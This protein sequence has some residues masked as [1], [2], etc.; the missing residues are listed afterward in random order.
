MQLE[1]YQITGQSLFE[2]P[3]DSEYDYKAEPKILFNIDFK[4]A[5]TNSSFNLEDDGSTPHSDS[6]VNTLLLDTF[7]DYF[8]QLFNNDE[9]KFFSNF[10]KTLFSSNPENSFFETRQIS[11][12]GRYSQVLINSM[13]KIRRIIA[14][15]ISFFFLHFINSLSLKDK[16]KIESIT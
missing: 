9:Q 12:D 3:Y 8:G 2:R 16:R 7:G 15:I 1:N 11:Y 13:D 10:R 14:F 5:I 4:K 6:V